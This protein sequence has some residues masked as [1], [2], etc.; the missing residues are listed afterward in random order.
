MDLPVTFWI[1][2]ISPLVLCVPAV[3]AAKCPQECFCDQ[4][5]LTVTC[6]NKNLTQVPPAVDEVSINI[7]TYWSV[8]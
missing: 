8:C 3:Q 5:Q 6:V 4:I 7:H 2:L 1:L